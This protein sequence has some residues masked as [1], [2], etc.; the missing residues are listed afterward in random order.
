MTVLYVR[1]NSERACANTVMRIVLVGPPGA[2]K[3]T[4][5]KILKERF[6][7]P[8]IATGDLLRLKT[9]DG[10]EI[11]KRAKAVMDKGQ[12]VP[13]EMV[14]EMIRERLKEPDAKK[15]FILDGFPRTVE[16]AKALDKMLAELAIKLDTVLD[17]EVSEKIVLNRLSGRRICPKCNAGYHVHNIPP[18]QEGICDACGAKLVQRKDDEPATVLER[19]KVYKERTAPLIDYYEKKGIRSAIDGDLEVEPLQKELGKIFK[20]LGLK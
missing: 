8:H 18:K 11:G 7:V 3:G 19:L 9:Q 5:A 6:K 2:G 10:S 15:G 17:F 20:S 1:E 16:Q 12:L 14:I 13:D 4:H